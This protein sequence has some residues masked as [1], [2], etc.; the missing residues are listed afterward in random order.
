MIRARFRLAATLG[1]VLVTSACGTLPVER[2]AATNVEV[3]SCHLLTTPEENEAVSDTKPAVPCTSDHTSETFRIAKL[4]GSLAASDSRPNS[5]RLAAVTSQYCTVEMLRDYLG[6]R[7]RDTSSALGI[8]AYFPETT[9]WSAGDRTVRCDLVVKSPGSDEPVLLTGSLQDVM[10]TPASARL[11][12]CY[13]DAPFPEPSKEPSLTV[14]LCSEPH[15]G[16]DINAWL[17]INNS[18]P[19]EAEVLGKC[20]PFAEE[21]FAPAPIPEGVA[22]TGIVVPGNGMSTLRCAVRSKDSK[23]LKGTLLHD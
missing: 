22:V 14:V 6:A 12:T 17:N 15:V 23:T 3:S 20:T 21:F 5:S 11:R 1:I 2:P 9:A 16:E 13:P 8:T 18:N 19:P 10:A 4:L 7:D